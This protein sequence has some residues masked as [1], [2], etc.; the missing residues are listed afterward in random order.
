L[1][2]VGSVKNRYQVKDEPEVKIDKAAQQE[3]LADVCPVAAFSFSLFFF[4]SFFLFCFSDS[5]PPFGADSVG[6]ASVVEGT[7]GRLPASC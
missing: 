6:Q 5:I 2:N 7:P 1:K 3:R 4:L